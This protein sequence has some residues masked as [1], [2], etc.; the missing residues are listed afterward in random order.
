MFNTGVIMEFTFK[1]YPHQ[2][3][4][5][6]LSKREKH[7]ALLWDMGTGKTFGVINIIRQKC[8]EEN[9]LKRVLILSPLVT[10]YNWQ[11][12]ISKYSKIPKDRVHVMHGSGVKRNKLLK[13]SITEHEKPNRAAV[14]IC[15]WEALR[16]REFFNLLLEWKPEIIVGDELHKIKSYKS[17]TAKKAVALADICRLENGNVYGLTG[18]MI[19]NSVED[20]Y[21]QYRFLDGGNLFYDNFF[22][23]RNH[24]MVNKNEA[25]QGS[26]SFPKWEANPKTYKELTDKIYKI[27]T[28]V[29]KD[30]AMPWLPPLIKKKLY[31]EMT[32]KQTRMYK[33]MRDEFITWIN[34]Q[35]TNGEAPA[36]VANL[37][38]TKA[39]RLMQIVTGFVKDEDGKESIIDDKNPRLDAVEDIL[40]EVITNHKVIL[41]CSFKSNYK[42]LGSLCDKMNIK[43]VLV[44]GGQSAKERNEAVNSFQRDDSVR[45][46][47]GNRGAAGIGINLTAASYSIIYSRNFSLGEELQ[48]EARNHRG[49]SEVHQKI[50]KIDL[51]AKGTIDEHVLEALSNKQKISDMIIDWGKNE[52]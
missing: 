47:I 24:Y 44:S 48:S 46:L 43:Y 26:K 31:V 11:E 17:M 29:T 3:E 2:I 1:P 19:L 23:F 10:L 15:N 30:E 36:V 52:L 40:D 5:I 39:L 50:I 28:R 6:E 22:R 25:W 12:E 32:P 9:R 49:G 8:F 7:V 13:K 16:T 18:T 27:A 51:V 37:A 14:I 4:I 35:E 33:E 34:E 21:M 41:W 45:V 42:Q 20:V 38:V